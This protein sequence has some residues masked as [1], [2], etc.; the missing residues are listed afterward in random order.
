MHDSR[1]IIKLQKRAIRIMTLSKY[2]AHTEPLFKELNLLKIRGIYDIQC[3]KFWCKFTK[4]LLSKFFRSMFRYNYEIHDIESRSHESLHLFSNRT[5]GARLVLRH[6]I[7]KLLQTFPDAVL[8][9]VRTH[10]IDNFVSHVK[11]Y[12]YIC[13]AMSVRY[14]TVLFVKPDMHFVLLIIMSHYRMYR[15]VERAECSLIIGTGCRVQVLAWSSIALRFVSW[16]SVCW[17]FGSR[18][19]LGSNHAFSRGRQLA[20]FRIENRLPVPEHRN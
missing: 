2:N 9:K 1:R 15:V 20:S 7:P 11:T 3:T 19:P 13:I 14:P 12:L 16:H 5:S 8:R 6:Y 18:D 10:N 17:R 4:S